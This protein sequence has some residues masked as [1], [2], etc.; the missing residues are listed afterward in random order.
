MTIKKII[1]TVAASAIVVS[2]MSASVF[3]DKFVNSNEGDNYIIDL[4]AEG[5]NVTEVC[6]VTFTI[7][8]DYASSG[9]G[10]GIG[11]N[12]PSTGWDQTEW[13]N[14]DANKAI[15]L[16]E[17]NKVTL[18]RDA[19]VFKESDTT[20]DNPHAQVWISKWWGN[21]A[22]VDKVEVLGAG[23]A[24]LSPTSGAEPSEPADEASYN[25]DVQMAVQDNVTWATQTSEKVN[26]NKNGEYTFKLDGLS[27]APSALT[28]LYIKDAYA[29][30]KG[31]ALEAGYK[32]D[33]SNI[34]LSYSLKINGKDVAVDAEAPTKLEDLD[35]ADVFDFAL[36]NTWAT[37][38]I[39]LPEETITSVELVVNVA[40]GE[41]SAPVESQPEESKPEES[42]PE[43]SKAEESKPEES[44]AEES[45]P[46]E[47]Q[48]APSA[49]E[50]AGNV[51]AATGDKNSPDTGVEGVAAV[52][53]VAA[54]AGLAVVIVKKRK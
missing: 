11:F 32:S 39:T 25:V 43:E 54:I 36:F 26:I 14:A 46:A 5:Y 2:A 34:V 15:T 9:I 51:N 37:S 50:A 38:Y 10:G 16:T 35:K 27:I 8:G 42:Q 48:A 41:G 21:D 24:V 22:T 31:D 20:G 52:V 33:I 7:S 17:D 3:A 13:G 23:G 44:K 6:G 49:T 29:L 40:S 4:I 53:G 19:P 1:A 28:V 45:Q 12:S 18:L 30:E 47:S